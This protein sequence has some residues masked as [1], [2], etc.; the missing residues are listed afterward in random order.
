MAKKPKPPRGP[1]LDLAGNLGVAFVNTASARDWN[2]QQGFLTYA[3]LVIWGQRAGVLDS[4]VAERLRQLAAERPADAEAVTARAVE[5]RSNLFRVLLSL[6]KKEDP[7]PEHLE[8]LNAALTS[9]LPAL[10]VVPGESGLIWDWGGDE[11]A[12]DRMVW[13]PVH[14]VAHLLVSTEDASRLR[15]C[16][17]KGCTLFFVA[18]DSRRKWCGEVCRNR[19]KALSYYH[20]KVR[21]PYLE[22]MHS[23]GLWRVKRPRKRRFS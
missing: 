8:V 6:A 22:R 23:D 13:A 21:G 5:L 20:R 9:S 14:A 12:L 2:F 3:E 19:S 4:R 15:Q 10:R 11:A 1:Q 16:A 7:K 18:R 17:R